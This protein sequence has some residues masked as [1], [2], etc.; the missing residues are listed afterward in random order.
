MIEERARVIEAGEGYAWVETER[1]SAC[2]SCRVNPGC[3]TAVL[4]KAMGRRRVRLRALSGIPVQAGDEVVVGIDES[5]L[6][7]GS[8]AVYMAPL[9]AML[10]GAAV[11]EQIIG[12]EAASMLLGAAGLLGSFL[13]LRHAGGIHDNPQF[14]PVVLRRL[15]AEPGAGPFRGRER[16]A[17]GIEAG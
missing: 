6:I 8:L 13:W 10:A 1:R 14:Q 3:G 16:C 9:L 4:A 2:G 17:P 5:A 12:S 11:G 15:T 7:Q